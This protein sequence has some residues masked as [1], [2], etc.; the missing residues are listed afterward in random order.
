[1]QVTQRLFYFLDKSKYEDLVAQN[2]SLDGQIMQAMSR[3]STRQRI[4]HVITNRFMESQSLDLAPLVAY[5]VAD[6]FDHRAIHFGPVEISRPSRVQVVRA[7]MRPTDCA[8][9]I[10][11]ITF[12]PEFGYLSDTASHE[13]LH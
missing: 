7:V 10:A 3:S 11:E 5:T 13:V 6:R 12:T 4:H 8:W 9:K 2:G 1:M